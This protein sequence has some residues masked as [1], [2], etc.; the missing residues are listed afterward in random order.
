M[1]P[2][3]QSE[4]AHTQPKLSPTALDVPNIARTIKE[5]W[6]KSI[7]GILKV[8]QECAKARD[9]LSTAQKQQLYKLLPFK[10]AMFS[11]LASIGE[12]PRLMQHV[13][14][15][16]LSISTMYEAKKLPDDRFE[17]AI[18]ENVLRPD[19]KREDFRSWINGTV[20]AARPKPK[21]VEFPFFL[22]CLYADT[23]PPDALQASMKEDAIQLADTF[24]M[25]IAT[26]TGESR[27]GEFMQHWAKKPKAT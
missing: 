12:D 14:L 27:M 1:L 20:T 19:V 23:A 4:A 3:T 24:G 6:R 13:D 7:E 25:K 2:T 21:E 11:K 8:A 18:K 9:Q 17:A 15:L 26:F 5:N 16:P 22:M 10:E